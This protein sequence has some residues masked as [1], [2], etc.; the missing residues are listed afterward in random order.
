MVLTG[1]FTGVKEQV[2]GTYAA[3]LHELRG[4]ISDGRG[5]SGM[6]SFQQHVNELAAEG[7]ISTET[8]RAVGG[9]AE[10]RSKSRKGSAE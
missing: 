10:R 3:R 8:A 6:Q 4:L 9:V 7:T 5:K 1:P 2:V